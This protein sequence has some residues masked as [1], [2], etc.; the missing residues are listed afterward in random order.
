MNRRNRSLCAL[1]LLATVGAHFIDRQAGLLAWVLAGAQFLLYPQL[2]YLVAARAAHPRQAEIRN[3]LLDGVCFGT[4]AAALGFPVWITFIFLV[5]VTVNLTVFLGRRGFFQAVA[6]MVVGAIPS[7]FIVTPDFS[8]ATGWPATLLA[9]LTVC[10]YVM[11]VAE[12]AHAR[13]LSLQEARARL[14]ESELALKQ[15]LEEISGLQAQLREQADRD[16]LTGLYNRRYFDASLARELARCQREDL[17]LSLVMIDID[18]FKK[19]NDQHGHQAGDMVLRTLADLLQHQVRA[20]DI[21]CRYGGEEFLVLLPSAP[22]EVA[23]QRVDEWRQAFAAQ[24][25]VAGGIAVRASLS[26]GV[27]GVPHHALAPEAL[28]R[29]ADEA[30]YRA[31]SAGRDCVVVAGDTADNTV[32]LA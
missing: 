19:I 30:L 11:I 9:I 1:L 13:A 16:P 15:Q 3:L 6:A 17:P 25:V 8:P 24:R 28:L 31:K 20:S 14:R 32:S 22:P 18:H 29:R 4:W 12:N 27:A 21:A 10:V 23:R 7:W 2:L 5:T 26:A